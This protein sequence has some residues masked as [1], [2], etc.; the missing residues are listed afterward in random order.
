L[1][2]HYGV[3]GLQEENHF[4]FSSFIKPFNDDVRGIIVNQSAIMAGV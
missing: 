2:L 1:N 4:A 3:V